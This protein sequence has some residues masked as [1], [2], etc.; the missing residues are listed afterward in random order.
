[1]GEKI[2]ERKEIL[3]FEEIYTRFVLK[4]VNKEEVLQSHIR[5]WR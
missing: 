4:A 5:A 2:D 3:K 1:M